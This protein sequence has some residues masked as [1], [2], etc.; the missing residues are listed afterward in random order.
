MTRLHYFLIAV[1]L[2]IFNVFLIAKTIGVYASLNDLE[3]AFVLMICALI[4]LISIVMNAA[5]LM[6]FLFPDYNDEDLKRHKK[7]FKK[8]LGWRVLKEVIDIID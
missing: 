8:S 2:T 6:A 7:K 4:G 3:D 1:G 5:F